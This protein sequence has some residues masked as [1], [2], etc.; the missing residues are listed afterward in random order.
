MPRTTAPRHTWCGRPSDP[1]PPGPG[2][3]TPLP[4]HLDSATVDAD[5]PGAVRRTLDAVLCHRV[6]QAAEL[7]AG[8]AR[9]VAE[10][11]AR[12]TL[13]GG[14]RM[15]A[16]FLWWALRACG[17]AGRAQTDAALRLAAGLE[18]LQTCALAHDDVMDGSPLRRGRPA[19]H[20][21]FAALHPAPRFPRG[22]EPFGRAAAILAGDLALA[23]ADDIVAEVGLG[24]ETAA[25]VRAIWRALRTEMVAGQY[26]DLR[27][28]ATASRS[29]AQA[30][31]TAC[32][33]S[34]LY[35]VE[36]PVL[37]GAALAG[38]DT[39]TVRALGSA[40]RC[41][42]TAFQ[43][44]DDL[45]G[46]FGDPRRTGKP[47]G[48]DLREGKPT[49]LVAVAR[50]RATGAKD[51]A[52]L[53]VLDRCLGVGDLPDSELAEVRRVLE[54]TGARAA[55]EAKIDRLIARSGGHLAAIALRPPGRQRLQELMSAA[56]GAAPAPEDE[57]ASPP[58]GIRSYG[59][60]R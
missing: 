23:W 43:L 51:R 14:K 8:F 55:V 49:Y 15:R 47:S 45:L 59:G 3:D 1:R 29:P 27:G 46:A 30:L 11:V 12:F 9:E 54:A 57:P 41:A 38:A 25:R 7:D 50:R 13:H 37:L 40:G 32:M 4:P 16:R 10:R 39:A 31:R 24:R 36:R 26:L 53:A 20:G 35:S 5:V 6:E 52:A 22:G 17:G 2:A 21:E 18:L 34:G 56:A 48:D 58:A 28:Q 42:G 44:H 60:P 33:K 19:L